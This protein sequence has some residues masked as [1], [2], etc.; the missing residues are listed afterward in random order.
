MRAAGMHRLLASAVRLAGAMRLPGWIDSLS[1][2]G[3]RIS[4]CGNAITSNLNDKDH[5]Y[6]SPPTTLT[7]TLLDRLITGDKFAETQDL[8]AD[9]DFRRK[10][11][12]TL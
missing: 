2:K 3:T 4:L 8:S 5:L 12:N 10:D 11:L 1:P 7:P 9:F 6:Q